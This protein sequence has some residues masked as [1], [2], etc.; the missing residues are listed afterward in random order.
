MTS[1]VP[2]TASPGTRPRVLLASTQ[3]FPFAG[4]LSPNARRSEVVRVNTPGHDRAVTDAVQRALD[5]AVHAF[6]LV[7]A[8]A[9]G[10]PILWANPAFEALTGVPRAR[11]VGRTAGS[12]I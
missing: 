12:L 9:D 11:L 3:S 6:A 5:Q 8:D 10:H 4:A 7:D 1:T 2:G